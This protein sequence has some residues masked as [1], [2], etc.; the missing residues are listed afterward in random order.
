MHHFLV[1]FFSLIAL[2]RWKIY[3]FAFRD[4]LT[5]DDEFL[6]Y[7]YTWISKVFKNSIPGKFAN[8]WKI[9]PGGIIAMKFEIAQIHFW[10]TF[11]NWESGTKGE[12]GFSRPITPCS[13]T[14]LVPIIPHLRLSLVPSPPRLKFVLPAQLWASLWRRHPAT[15]STPKEK[16]IEEISTPQ[17]NRQLFDISLIHISS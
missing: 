7:F 5:Q 6:L 17:T 3:S 8:S 15:S 12:Q 10:V 14:A 4:L 13:R 9:K 1:H 2:Q 11:P 16:S